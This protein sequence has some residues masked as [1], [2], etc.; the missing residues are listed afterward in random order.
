VLGNLIGALIFAQG[1]QFHSLGKSTPVQGVK[2]LADAP[3][4]GL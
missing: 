1:E 3:D 4:L 2:K